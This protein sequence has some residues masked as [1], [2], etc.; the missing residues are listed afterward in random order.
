VLTENFEDV[1]SVGIVTVA[2]TIAVGLA[3]ERFNPVPIVK[4]GEN[5]NWSN[6]L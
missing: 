6:S 2:G 4:K 1:A 3:L 5:Y